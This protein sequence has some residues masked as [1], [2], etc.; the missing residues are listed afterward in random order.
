MC[1]KRPAGIVRLANEHMARA[2]RVISV[3]RGHNPADYSL[4]CFGGAGGLHACDLAELLDM[5][6]Y[7]HSGPVRCSVGHGHAG[8]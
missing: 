7:H 8:Q 4:L 2:L 1:W 6:R 5:E 3:E